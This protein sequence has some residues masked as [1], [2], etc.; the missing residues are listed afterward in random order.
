M[1]IYPK[2][3]FLR[4]NAA[5]KPYISF[6]VRGQTKIIIAASTKSTKM[7]SIP[8]RPATRVKERRIRGELINPSTYP[9]QKI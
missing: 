8:G 7:I 1:I 4:A 9:A 3:A 2:V 6:R 5:N